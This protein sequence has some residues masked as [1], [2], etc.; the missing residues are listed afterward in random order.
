MRRL[1]L[2]NAGSPPPA[3][4]PGHVSWATTR[5]GTEFA[6]LRAG[7]QS[8]CG[9]DP[10]QPPGIWLGLVVT[11]EASLDHQGSRTRLPADTLLYGPTGTPASLRFTTDF[12]LLLVTIPGRLLAYRLIDPVELTVHPAGRRGGM[13][14]VLFAWLH[15]IARVIDDLPA[16]E[17]AH[18]ESAGAEMLIGALRSG[19]A[20]EGPADGATAALGRIRRAIEDALDDPELCIGQIGRQLGLSPRYIQKAF[21]ASG[22]TFTAY[23]LRRRLARCHHDLSNP[24]RLAMSISQI[25][26]SHGF[27]D[28]AHFSKS[29]RAQYGLAPGAWRKKAV[30]F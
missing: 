15:A 22:Q 18:L 27:N 12:R 21:S 8:L 23:V 10:G 13:L 1:R 6:H 28:A 30:L 16:A 9:R 5:R 2:S 11:G 20:A 19:R 26:F 24:G 17:L 25:C 4:F 14:C 7:P 29:F 3:A